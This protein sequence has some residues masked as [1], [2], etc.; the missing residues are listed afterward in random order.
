MDIH[1]SAFLANE[2]YGIELSEDKFEELALIAYNFIGNKNCKLYRYFAVI[3][4]VTL[5]VEL[6]CNAEIIEAVTGVWEDWQ[7]VTNRDW[8]GDWDSNLIEHYI[9]RSKIFMDPL[10]THGKYLKYERVGD[11]LYFDRPYGPIFILYK[12]QILDD[13]GLPEVNDKEA[14]A[15][16]TYIAYVTK[17]K[18]GL[19]T[20][21]KQVMEAAKMLEHD[22]K[23][24]CDQARVPEYINQNEMDQILDAK[25]NWN[26]KRFSKS[27][28]PIR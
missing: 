24:K 26:R 1:Y 9:E 21:N 8:N 23:V 4:P 20:M 2:L 10:Y 19:I 27:L 22:W 28:K 11:K 18:E 5:C 6:P 17:Y 16:A 13:N 25:S 14:L 15:I 7:S 12:G 3:N